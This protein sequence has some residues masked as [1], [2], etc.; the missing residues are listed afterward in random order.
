MFLTCCSPREVNPIG[1]R[2]PIWSRTAPERQIPP[3]CASASS[4]AAMLTPSPNRFCPST[5]TSPRW[6]PMR[7]RICWPAGRSSFSFSMASW[8]ATAHSTAS[9]GLAKSATKLSPAV[10]KIRPRWAAINRSRMARWAPAPSA[11]CTRQYRPQRSRQAFVRLP[12]L[13]PPA[14][15]AGRCCRERIVP[16]TNIA[17]IRALFDGDVVVP[18]HLAESAPV[19]PELRRIVGPFSVVSVRSVVISINHDARR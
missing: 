4:R 1:R 10:L 19:D 8:T 16:Q 12:G 13:L 6:M 18:V 15:L 14:L 2:E 7:N 5:R 11:G 9:T 3:G 17:I